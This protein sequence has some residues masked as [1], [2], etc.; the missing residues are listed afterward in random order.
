MEAKTKIRVIKKGERNPLLE[1]ITFVERQPNKE[2]ARRMITTVM[3]WVSDF[4]DRKLEETRIAIERF[5]HP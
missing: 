4:Q 2:A 1:K 3:D 5:Q